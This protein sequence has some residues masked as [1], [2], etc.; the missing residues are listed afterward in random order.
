[1]I[2]SGQVENGTVKLEGVSGSASLVRSKLTGVSI[3]NNGD[4]TAEILM[5]GGMK[6]GD[7]AYVY[8]RDDKGEHATLCA[9]PRTRQSLQKQLDA[10]TIRVANL[11]KGR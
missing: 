9:I 1:M 6:E 5:P 2:R 10:L 7:G 11:E 3:K 8:W 4:G